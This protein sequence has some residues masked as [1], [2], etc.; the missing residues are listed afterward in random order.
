MEYQNP[1]LFV[2]PPT[3]EDF[4]SQIINSGVFPENI[5]VVDEPIDELNQH[6][7]GEITVD[8]AGQLL[9][10]YLRYEG[11]T[12]F[13][14]EIYDDFIKNRLKPIITTTRILTLGDGKTVVF[15]FNDILRPHH[16]LG[17]K[18][19]PL[20]PHKAW[21]DDLTYDA[22]IYVDAVLRDRN[23]VEIE[24]EPAI[25]IGK[26]PVML[27][28][29]LCHLHEMTPRQRAE[30][31]E[32][33]YDPHGYFIVA[34]VEKV[35][36]LREKLRL[37]KI[38]L[39]SEATTLSRPNAVTC[40][41]TISVNNTTVLIRLNFGKRNNIRLQLPSLRKS[42]TGKFRSVSVLQ[43]YRLFGYNDPE[44]IMNIMALFLD[45]K[46]AKKSLVELTSSIVKFEINGEPIEYFSQKMGILNKP[47]DER[48]EIIAHVIEVDLFPHLNYASNP[49]G[50]KEKIRDIRKLYMLSIM[51][52]RMIEYQAGF[53]KL[54]DR[55]SWSNKRLESG[56]RLIEPLF[57][58]A[59]NRS[60]SKIQDD[61]KKGSVRDFRG[62]IN[63]I[64]PS[65]IID[66]FRDSFITQ[67]WGIKGYF[68][69]LNAT[70]TLKRENLISMLSHLTLINVTLTRGDK[71]QIRLVQM[72][73]Y[74]YVCPI[75]TPEG[76]GC[77]IL[78][79][80]AITA[81]TSIE[82][83]ELIVMS[84][85]EGIPEMNIPRRVYIT[86][87]HNHT[88]K[89]LLNG[90]FLGWCLAEQTRDFCIAM[91]RNGSFE[92]DTCIVLDKDNYLYIHTDS[93]R[94]IRPL[95]IVGENGQLEI[96]NKK[97][98]G[99]SFPT[100][101][102]EGCLEYIDAW[103]Q[104]YIKLAPSTNALQSYL[105]N[106][107]NASE[108]YKQA[109]SDLQTIK[110]GERIFVPVIHE[111]FESETLLSLKDAEDR[112]Q[113]ALQSLENIRHHRPYTH[114]EID[115]IAIMGISAAII[116]FPQHNQG[117][118]NTYQAN[119]GTQ[120]LGIYHSNSVARF[121][122]K[123]KTLAYPSRPLF[124]PELNEILGLNDYPQGEQVVVAFATTTGY[125]QED[126]F[127]FNRA[128]I[129]VGKF[130]MFKYIRYTTV[131]KSTQE[132][133][134]ELGKPSSLSPEHEIRYRFINENGLPTIGAY[135]KT[136]DYVT[137]KIQRVIS[138]GEKKNDGTTLKVGDEGIVD[139]VR[140]S[141]DDRT[142]IVNVRLRMMRI[143]I[144]GDKFAPR[145]AQKGTIG[146]II[147][148][149]DMPFSEK[150]GIIPDIIVNVHSLP[151]RMTFSYFMEIIAG[152]YGALR[153]ERINASAFRSFDFD[154]ARQSLRHY[155]YNPMG[156]EKMRSGI[157]G[158][159][160]PYELFMGPCYFQALKHHV[161]DKQQARDIGP[162]STL[163]RQPVQGRPNKGGIRFGEMERDASLSHGVSMFIREKFCLAADK[164]QMVFC[165][166]CG[167][168]PISNVT[169]QSYRCRSCR[170][171]GNFGKAIIPYT[172]KLFQQYVAIAG[173]NIR[174]DMQ[175]DEERR[176]KILSLKEHGDADATD[177]VTEDIKSSLRDLEE[178][179]KEDEEIEEEMEEEMEEEDIEDPFFAD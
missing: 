176:Q 71:P 100:L 111:G 84:H 1:E 149:E 122:V 23:E 87:D 108:Y 54:D 52:S 161:R 96:D 141:T 112:V 145:Y 60:L 65:A 142:T 148:P 118:R 28:S 105:D 50:E 37:N 158:K 32:D 41:S 114:C 77:G 10:R 58:A 140:V 169:T 64:K 171:R 56:G 36:M 70:Q 103:E 175:T 98:R 166:T 2:P 7:P 3:N 79:N 85:L 19:L 139:N 177:V 133:I 38:L 138:T 134:E 18:K 12:R 146:R 11:F 81:R 167:M 31:G 153:G 101:L 35:I 61:I 4:A 116:P 8:K 5:A 76:K 125:T 163:T 82:R 78:K 17:G 151:S 74:G 159:L 90:K 16:Y 115:P 155:G 13:L 63:S 144:E 9:K 75:K 121:E 21:E 62:V 143:P 135:L 179:L 57:R 106:I 67:N 55:D 92:R 39:Y 147:N 157:T 15:Y 102:S 6:V 154:E 46:T 152:K 80:L 24:R 68:N 136:G 165:K 120:A 117:P 97:L 127:V 69:V 29:S 26:L 131:V 172:F 109:Q 162:N 43:V 178:E 128:S 168:N 156:Y 20:L 107:R 129:D 89:V 34:G 88:G 137:G 86:P 130:R 44:K 83:D 93:S 94:V 91:R 173:I 164:Y 53:R 22:E 25:L 160:M 40:K 47:M 14:I 66:V 124:E 132:V 119:M 48:R 30:V 27:R 49:D 170:E 51:V 150:S 33:P 110:K 95:L 126:A 113:Q 73:Q 104:E 72:S 99:A 42:E 123:A 59:W 174:F 45:P